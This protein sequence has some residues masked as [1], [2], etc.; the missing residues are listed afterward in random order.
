MKTATLTVYTT[1]VW[2][3]VGP[4]AGCLEIP[5]AGTTWLVREKIFF[6][7]LKQ[8][9]RWFDGEEQQQPWGFLPL[10]FIYSFSPSFKHR[11]P[12]KAFSIC[13][14]RRSQKRFILLF[15]S[16]SWGAVSPTYPTYLPPSI[17]T[18]ARIGTESRLPPGS[19]FFCLFSF[20]S[21]QRS[22]LILFLKRRGRAKEVPRIFFLFFFLVCRIPYIPR[23]AQ[24]L[25]LSM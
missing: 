21:C 6:L 11:T 4:P 20:L 23:R 14:T 7:A 15:C 2:I 22:F 16:L 19:I 8:P 9:G 24:F 17:Q 18:P 3:Y 5:C 10:F 25:L 13:A 12:D 1:T